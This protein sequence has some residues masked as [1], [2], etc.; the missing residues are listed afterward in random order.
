MIINDMGDVI[1]E[2][3]L[4]NKRKKI[5]IL[6]GKPRRFPD[7]SDYLTP[8]QIVGIGNEKISYGAG[9]DAIQSL[10]LTMKMIGYDLE[11]INRTLDKKLKW[12][13]D[14]NGDLGF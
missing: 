8:Y 5:R 6:I 7:S 3:K 11:A 12:D 13:G 1:A 2:R 4:S 14:E 9:I 10:Q